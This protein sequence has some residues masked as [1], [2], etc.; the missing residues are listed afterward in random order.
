MIFQ[1][2]IIALLVAVMLSG[3]FALSTWRGSRRSGIIWLFLV[4]FLASWAGG[5]WLRP[6]G[7]E[8]QDLRWLGFL[9]I[10]LI[11]ALFLSLRPSPNNFRGG[12]RETLDMLERIKQEEEIQT[13]TFVTLSI[14]FW[15]L[16]VLLILA[17]I[18]RYIFP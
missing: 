12:R 18:V 5:I 6:F 17:I 9:I 16:I 3:I 11:V 7:T 14:F 13:V 15:V 8:T 4:L 2:I 1:D 10:G